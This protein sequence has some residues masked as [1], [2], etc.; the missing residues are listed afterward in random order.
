MALC[1]HLVYGIDDTVII[2][3]L[4]CFPHWTICLKRKNNAL[5]ILCLALKTRKGTVNE[6][7]INKPYGTQTWDITEKLSLKYTFKMGY[8]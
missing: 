2:C 1:M 4:V 8:F 5:F 7:Q 6:E 3:S